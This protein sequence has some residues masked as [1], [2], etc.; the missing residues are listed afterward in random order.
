MRVG[1]LLAGAAF[2]VQAPRLVLA[3]LAADRLAIPASTERGLLTLAAVGT[4]VVLTGGGIYLA[5]SALT[6]PRWRPA[7][8]AAWLLVLTASAGLVAPA[9]AGGLAGEHLYQVLGSPGLRQAWATLAA[10]AHEVT[11]AGCMLAAAA[12]ARRTSVEDLELALADARDEV[13]ELRGQ[14]ERFERAASELTTRA[15]AAER[16][17]SELTS[18]LEREQQAVSEL[19]DRVER[20]QERARRA[21]QEASEL[22]GELRASQRAATP[23]P[24][25]AQGQPPVAAQRCRYC[26]RTDFA[27]PQARAAHEGR[28]PERLE[29]K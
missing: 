25:P 19:S 4:A 29:E 20:A 27:T 3:V 9:I 5:H 2:L 7:L 14:L 16:V 1:Y 12:S 23:A 21:E 6:A 26:D 13:S 15:A 10:L 17:A 22:R 18:E 28:C 8:G 24:Q 11:A